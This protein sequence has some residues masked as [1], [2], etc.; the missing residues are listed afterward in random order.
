[1]RA[2]TLT[3]ITT[4]AS[5]FQ[6][7]FKLETNET[8]GHITYCFGPVRWGKQFDEQLSFEDY[9]TISKILAAK[10]PEKIYEKYPNARP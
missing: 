6:V 2:L 3:D 5:E 8:P 4:L 10:F 7:E 9:I 1:M